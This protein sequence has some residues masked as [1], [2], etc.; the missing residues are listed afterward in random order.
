MYANINGSNQRKPSTLTAVCLVGT[1]LMT[2]EV[3]LADAVVPSGMPVP[4]HI[5]SKFGLR[6]SPFSGQI[7]FHRGVDI[8]ARRGTKVVA[9]ADGEV[10]QA[11]WQG[12]CG[13][14]VTLRHASGFDTQYC[15]LDRVRVLVGE[16]V[17][18][19]SVIGTVGSTGRSAGPH[20]HYSVSRNGKP[21]D[22]DPFLQ[23][24][25]TRGPRV[26]SPRRFHA[27]KKIAAS[28]VWTVRGNSQVQIPNAYADLLSRA[29]WLGYVIGNIDQLDFIKAH[30]L[31]LDDGRRSTGV[32]TVRRGRR[33]TQVA[34]LGLSPLEIVK[35]IVHGAAHLEHWPRSRR[36]GSEDYATKVV[37][38]FSKHLRNA[39]ARADILAQT[40]QDAKRLQ[41]GMKK[42]AGRMEAQG[43]DIRDVKSQIEGLQ[44]QS[45][46]DRKRIEARVESQ[47]RD[48]RDIK[49]N[50]RQIIE[51]LNRLE[52]RMGQTKGALDS[53]REFNKRRDPNTV[54]LRGAI[55]LGEAEGQ[56][57]LGLAYYY[58]EDGVRR[59]YRQAAKCFRQA[60][61][62]GDATAQLYMGLLRLDGEGVQQ[63]YQQAVRWF[64]RATHQGNAR[65]QYYLALCYYYGKGIRRDYE[66]AIRWFRRAAQQGHAPSQGFLGI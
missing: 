47:E 23:T 65:G 9:T 50:Q 3:A 58:G 45:S 61:E 44:I 31:V 32:A 40:R 2:G 60:A 57:R 51:G 42:W 54:P 52:A 33:M 14:S 18:R 5:S 62:Q 35:V 11:G 13:R 21:L 34:T 38:R 64:R 1:L 49:G 66:E 28:V 36:L 53:R 22:P 15:H 39:Q 12:V 48:I 26:A 17:R 59:D 29:G 30:I 8:P 27:S 55:Q 63:D 20:L 16:Q 25:R 10:T 7:E 37:A 41:E 4:G 43:R 19:G 46:Q 24:G 6:K 56:R